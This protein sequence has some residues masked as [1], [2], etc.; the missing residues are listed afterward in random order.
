MS[1]HLGLAPTQIA[2]TLTHST[3]LNQLLV[4]GARL[5]EAEPIPR[6][7]TLHPVGTARFFAALL[8]RD[9]RP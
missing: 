8:A 5:W 6:D 3:M 2:R 4:G 7:A 9:A 1:V